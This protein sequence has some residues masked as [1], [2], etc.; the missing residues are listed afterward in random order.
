MKKVLIT[1]SNGYIGSH[2]IKKFLDHDIDVVAV[3][4]SNEWIDKRASF[5]SRDIFAGLQD[6][7]VDVDAVVHLAWRNGFEHNNLVHV[8]SLPGHIKFVKEVVECGVPKIAI[9]GTMHEVGYWEG[10]VVADTPCFPQS[11]YGVAKDALRNTAQLLCCDSG[12][13]LLWLRGFYLVGDNARSR[14]VFAKIEEAA[15]RGEKRF[16]FNSGK[17][18]YDFLKVDDAVEQMFYAIIQD[19]Y[20]GIINICS[21]SPVSLGSYVESFIREIN[22]DIQLEYGAYRDRPYDSPRIYGDNS[23][24][25]KIMAEA[26]A[27]NA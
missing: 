14:S 21:G 26:K 3:D 5:H 12:T 20:D 9:M 25:A 1:G 24:I 23:I 13:K 18:E 22:S 19:E 16:P 4:L 10:A 15:A 8:E 7:L 27:C 6:L 2:L 11:F 17:N